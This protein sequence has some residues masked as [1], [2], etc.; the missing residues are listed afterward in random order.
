M[1]PTGL[2]KFEI[3]CQVYC[4]GGRNRGRIG[5]LKG[6]DRHPGMFDIVH[7]Q[8]VKGEK[9]CAPPTFHLAHNTMSSL[10]SISQQRPMSFLS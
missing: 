8:D 2:L 7:I 1:R 9:V 5:E 10:Q 4:H 6:R 3:G